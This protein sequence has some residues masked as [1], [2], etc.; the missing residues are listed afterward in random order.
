MKL[1]QNIFILVFLILQFGCSKENES[2]Q[3]IASDHTP[4]SN[5][6]F[7]AND[8]FFVNGSLG[9]LIGTLYAERPYDLPPSQTYGPFI[10]IYKTLDGG[11]SWQKAKTWDC[12]FYGIYGK[13]IIFTSANRGLAF[14]DCSGATVYDSFNGGLGWLTNIAGGNGIYYPGPSSFMID[15]NTIVFRDIISRDGGQSFQ[16]LPYLPTP[17]LISSFYFKDTTYGVCS[18]TAGLIYKTNDLANTWDTLFNNSTYYFNSIYITNNNVLLAAANGEIL[19]SIDSGLNW[20]TAYSD[21]NDLV[22]E[23]EFVDS[24]IG[25]AVTT[26]VNCNSYIK[27]CPFSRSGK[28]LKTVDG[29]AS[30]VVNYSSNS[31][32]FQCIKVIDQ[33]Y[34]VVSGI[35]DSISISPT[36][37]HRSVN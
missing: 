15:T 34:Y 18:S 27:D 4:I 2:I 6:I 3:P 30:W 9:Y 24:Q 32:D 28:I 8:I 21:P 7:K 33:N 11:S 5:D 29:G 22:K 17:P 10:G 37:L 12:G 19:R 23:I 1:L 36:V 20:T 13:S 14:A 16:S 26:G 31:M 25:F 35:K